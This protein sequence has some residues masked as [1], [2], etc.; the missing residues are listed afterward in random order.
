MDGNELNDSIGKLTKLLIGMSA[1]E[2]RSGVVVCFTC[3]TDWHITRYYK[4]NV[5]VGSF[6]S[7]NKLVKTHYGCS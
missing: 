2:T 7:G 4:M 3:N 1:N 6:T 5:N